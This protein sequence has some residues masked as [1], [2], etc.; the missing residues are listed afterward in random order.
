[1][2]RVDGD[3]SGVGGVPD[4]EVDRLCGDP[5]A[6]LPDLNADPDGSGWVEVAVPA[7]GDAV[8]VLAAVAVQQRGRDSCVVAVSAGAGH[9]SDGSSGG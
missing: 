4:G 5:V 7:A 3:G 6:V 8:V 2:R 9:E 1:V